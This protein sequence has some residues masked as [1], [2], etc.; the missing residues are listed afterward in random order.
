MA[1]FKVTEQNWSGKHE[2][3]MLL[4]FR[5]KTNDEIASAVGLTNQSITRIRQTPYFRDRLQA[6]KNAAL[7][8]T[9][10]HEANALCGSKARKYLEK[11]LVTAARKVVR[12]MKSGTNEQALQFKAAQDILDRMGLKAVEVIETRERVYSPEEVERAKTILSE[13]ETI[14]ARLENKESRFMLARQHTRPIQQ[15]VVQ[16][17]ATDKGSDVPD[18][19]SES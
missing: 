19:K 12:I 16:S 6:M 13:V 14:I 11:S 9:I 15:D 10:E 8:K 7:K 18:E 2:K 4:T 5:G 1:V 17:S 3:I